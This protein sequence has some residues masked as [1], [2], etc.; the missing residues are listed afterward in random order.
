MATTTEDIQT[1]PGFDIKPSAVTNSGEVVFTDGTNLITPNQLQ[2]EAYGYTY[3]TATGSCYVFKTSTNLSTNITNVSNTIRGANNTTE[4]GVTNTSIMGENNIVRSLSRNN[5][6]VGNG[7]E[8]SAGVKNATI[9]G[10]NGLAQR[11][12]E[13]VIGGGAFQGI[14]AGHG[15]TSIMSL[16][17]KTTN[18]TP[19]A[20]YVNNSD[21]NTII[22][23]NSTS[24]FE[25]YD[26][27]VIGVRTGGSSGSG[28]ANDRVFFN[29]KGIIYLKDNQTSGLTTV[30]SSGT[31]T[32]WLTFVAFSGTND[33]HVQVKGATDMN[34]SWSGTLQLYQVIV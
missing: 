27:N 6:I 34:I 24:S 22:Q 2:C 26:L 7:N 32:G 19:T 9:L 8:I 3:D 31:V 18:A 16:S 13:V 11:D 12:G 33:L 21:T 14:G 29:Y 28:A 15:Q 23:R 30:A 17:G 20:L 10:N 4:R 5:I 1:L 25:A